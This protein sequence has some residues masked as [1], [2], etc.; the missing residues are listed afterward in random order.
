MTSGGVGRPGMVKKWWNP[1]TLVMG[2]TNIDFPTS[3]Y[4]R[5]VRWRGHA[6]L[7]PRPWAMT[8]LKIGERHIPRSNRDR[9]LKAGTDDPWKMKMKP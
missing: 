5:R 2:I 3:L 4:K 9:A 1:T 6:D 8:L 7:K